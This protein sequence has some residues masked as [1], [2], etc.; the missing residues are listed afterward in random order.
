MIP[1]QLRPS[2]VLLGLLLCACSAP[3]AGSG[4]VAETA[5]G[6][7]LPAE[8]TLRVEGS[9]R[10]APGEYLR[11]DP[12]NTGVIRIQGRRGVELDL[13]GVRLLGQGPGATSEDARGLGIVIEDCDRVTVR[14]GE[15]GGYLGCLVVLNSTDVTLEGITF[16]GYRADRLRGTASAA[17]P[18]DLLDPTFADPLDW[19]ARYGAAITI[20]GSSR[21]R[22]RDCRARG[23][24][25][26]ILLLGSEECEIEGNDLSFLSGWGVALARSSNNR[27]VG[28]RLDYIARGHAA[29]GPDQGFAACALLVVD[30]SSRN[31]FAW[32]SATRSGHGAL[33]FVGAGPP[34]V[35]AR[36]GCEENRFYRN[37]FSLALGQAFLDHGSTGTWVVGNELSGALGGGLRAVGTRDLVVY[38]NEVADV[39][40]AGVALEGGAQALVIGN[41]LRAC[42]QAFVVRGSG[43]ES[44]AEGG[45]WLVDNHFRENLQ[46]LVLEGTRGLAASG[47][48][49]EAV[50]RGVQCVEFGAEEGTATSPEVLWATLAGADGVRPSGRAWRSTLRQARGESHPALREVQR[51]E[52]PRGGGARPAPLAGA[53]PGLQGLWIGPYGPWDFQG[54]AP[55][56]EGGSPG[57]LLA[58]LA[59]DTSW[60][61]FDGRT[62]PRGD[63]EAWRALA[64]EPLYRQRVA[65]WADPW[66][67]GPA[68]DWVGE[69]DFGLVATARLVVPEAGRY[70][71]SILSDD[72]VRLLVDGEVV[73]EDW[74]WHPA[75]RDSAT[76][77]LEAG[78]RELRL[79]YFQ[80]DGPAALAVDLEPLGPTG[81]AQRTGLGLPSS[82]PRSATPQPSSP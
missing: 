36:P 2:P 59:W 12:G 55:R 57:G 72:G 77:E 67:G 63:L 40:A 80:L 54:S 70:R 64:F 18:A 16:A 74:T 53:P 5:Q 82:A 22:V 27:V 37:D 33:L 62:D 26:G 50:R 14:G 42:D 81:E 58:G 75:R 78:R 34:G 7:R 25:N 49:F 61:R 24:Q 28:N 71:L 13:R 46:D 60:F 79:E 73:Y 20:E 17:D 8:G 11:P 47:N 56:P 76:L 52:P 30:G 29:G 10:V 65:R 66:G 32:N 38:A 19:L 21:V 44:R 41:T 3:G 45:H 9:V 23:G 48:R 15:L 35:P 31:T 51:F 69:R 68:R 43:R 4:A 39:P 6:L 1:R